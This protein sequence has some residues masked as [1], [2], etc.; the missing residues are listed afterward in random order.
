MRD[1]F[2]GPDGMKKIQDQIRANPR[3]QIHSLKAQKD[4]FCGCF[5]DVDMK[6]L[7]W[8]GHEELH[9]GDCVYY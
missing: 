5:E 9:N 2:A 6:R 8:D 3:L 7:S 4:V 1:Y